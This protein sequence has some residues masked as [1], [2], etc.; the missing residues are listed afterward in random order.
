M[1]LFVLTNGQRQADDH[2]GL[3]F[4]NDSPC[5]SLWLL[6]STLKHLIHMLLTRQ[7]PHHARVPD[8]NSL[9]CTEFVAGRCND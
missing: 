6:S 2:S 7:L 3:R 1:P 9:T 4:S 5:E 8:W